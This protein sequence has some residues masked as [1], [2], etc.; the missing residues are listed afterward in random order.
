MHRRTAYTRAKAEAERV[1]LQM[2]KE[3]GL[4]V[5]IFRP[6]IVIGQG[7]DPCHWGVGMWHMPGV[8]QVWGEGRNPLPF[9]LVEDV[10]A[11]MILAQHAVQAVGKTFTLTDEPLLSARD[12]LAEIERAGGVKLQKHYT[13]TWWF[14]AAECM[15]YAVKIAVNHTNR[16]VPSW[17]DWNARREMSLYDTTS[18][19]QVLGWKPKG[20]RAAIIERGVH[21]PVR[22]LLK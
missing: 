6:G 15:K 22:E 4:P 21:R 10:A 8:C 12:Y 18:A 2:H 14:Y 11:G 16:T 19:R 7:G 17:R 20:E 13:P 1:L 9:V 3:Y 5:V